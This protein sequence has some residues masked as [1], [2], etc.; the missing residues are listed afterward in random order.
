[1]AAGV[2]HDEH[3]GLAVVRYYLRL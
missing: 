1:V 3:N 2:D